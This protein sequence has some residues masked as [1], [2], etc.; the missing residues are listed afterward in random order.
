MRVCVC[1]ISDSTSP[2]ARPRGQ[3]PLLQRGRIHRDPRLR[4]HFHAAQV[5]GTQVRRRKHTVLAETLTE[6]DG[7][8]SY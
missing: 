1:L 5:Q 7:G 2:T 4:R 3:E 8:R 6:S